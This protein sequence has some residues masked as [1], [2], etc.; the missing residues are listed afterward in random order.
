M[1]E[2]QKTIS[3]KRFAI[4][5]D[6]YF[7]AEQTRLDELERDGLIEGGTSRTI[8]VTPAGRIFVRTIAQ[9][10]DAFQSAAVASKAV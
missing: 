8:R 3:K 2:S 1:N 5:F 9:A 7:R 4:R 6:D 10:F